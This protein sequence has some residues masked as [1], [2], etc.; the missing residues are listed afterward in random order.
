MTFPEADAGEFNAITLEAISS[1]MEPNR[2]K[3]LFFLGKQGRTRVNDIASHFSIS[4]PAV[5]HHLKVLKTYGMV[6][7]KKSGQEEY[8]WVSI[9]QIIN[10]LRILAN[11]LEACCPPDG[12]RPKT[13]A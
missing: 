6:Q 4:R 10:H 3:I 2:L 1:M 5:S 9:G 11:E 13:T 7:S 8:Y 12:C